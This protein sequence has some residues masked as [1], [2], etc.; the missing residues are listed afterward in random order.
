[1]LTEPA[2][3]VRRKRK[4]KNLRNYR[5]WNC[6]ARLAILGLALWAGTLFLTASRITAQ[7]RT[8]TYSVLYNF[9]GGADGATP[10]ELIRDAAGNLYGTASYGGNTTTCTIQFGR[11]C[12]LV[13][14]LDQTGVET[15]LYTFIGGADGAVPYEGL[16]LDAD[17]NLY[18][19]TYAGGNTD[20][21]CPAGSQGCGVVF[22][23][24]Q[25]GNETV[26]YTFSGGSDGSEPYAGLVR[27]SSGNLY[28]TAA[29]GGKYDFGVVF[30]LD[31]AGNET[32]LHAFTF[33]PDGGEPT[34][35]LI[36]DPRGTLYGTTY[37]GSVFELDPLGEHFRVL[38]SFFGVSQGSYPWAGLV[39]DSSGNLYGTTQYGGNTGSSCPFG[40]I[41]CGVVFKVDPSGNETVLYAFTGG[42]DGSGSLAG[43]IRDRVGNLYGT[44]ATGGDF[45][46]SC[47]NGELGCGRRVQAGSLGNRDGTAQVQRNGWRR[48][49]GRLALL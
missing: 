38:Y 28:G 29:S 20:S 12:G 24:D 30:K 21:S 4:M 8:L 13:F 19:T 48:P 47:I 10:R 5:G 16:V 3:P 31:P 39:R 49:G 45:S 36:Q 26:L 27:D 2:L 34:A 32:V 46:N 33:G 17:G 15:V 40:S 23:V 6:S 44:T 42:S 11:G 43:L 7:E 35:P 1:L 25:G 14:K 37:V 41:G 18:G 22:K 9:T